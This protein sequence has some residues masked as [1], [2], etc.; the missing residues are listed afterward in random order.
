MEN[1]YPRI[2]TDEAGKG[3]YFGYLVIA[4][5]MIRT[6][7][8]EEKLVKAGVTDSKKLSDKRIQ[9]LA[10][11]ITA[12]YLHDI[13]MIS[14][15]K[16]NQL[17]EKFGNLNRLLAWGHARV[18]ENLLDQAPCSYAI[19]DQ[20]GDEKYILQ[21]LQKRG[22]AITV[23]QRPR[24]ESDVAV[25][26]GSILAR[27]TFVRTLARLSQEVGMELPKGATHIIEPGKQL[28]ARHGAD[29][30]AKVAKLHFRSTEKILGG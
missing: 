14:P 17:Y 28:V 2:G 29:I 16:Y 12:N 24:A 30:L 21:A 18:I 1:Y 10:S 22:K 27:A 8:E 13:V 9:A 11:E 20:F 25:A 23:V 15:A 6:P 3:D 7:E 26:A 4:G 5:V 19:S